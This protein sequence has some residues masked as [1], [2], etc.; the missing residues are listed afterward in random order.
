MSQS[1]RKIVG[2]AV[3]YKKT[4]NQAVIEFKNFIKA[5]HEQWEEECRE[6]K[7]IELEEREAQIEEN[8]QL[9][10]SE[11]KEIERIMKQT[12]RAEMENEKTGKRHEYKTETTMIT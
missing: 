4:D 5:R 6:L 12:K 8:R 3:G 11:A 9:A 2:T 10:G 1:F 7:R